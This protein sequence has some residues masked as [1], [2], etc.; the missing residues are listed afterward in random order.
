LVINHIQF[1]HGHNVGFM[2]DIMPSWN[3][4]V[5]SIDNSFVFGRESGNVH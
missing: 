2:V 5:T 1:V 4:I 3:R